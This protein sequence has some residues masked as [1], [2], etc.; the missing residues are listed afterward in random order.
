MQ[1]EFW[2]YDPRSS[3]VDLALKLV[4]MELNLIGVIALLFPQI[5]GHSEQICEILFT[6]RMTKHVK[7][8]C[9]FLVKNNFDVMTPFIQQIQWITT[10]F[11]SAK[12]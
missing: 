3:S 1:T 4:S 9:F 5:S 11:W 7:S 2:R 10:F 8:I 6:I 12:D